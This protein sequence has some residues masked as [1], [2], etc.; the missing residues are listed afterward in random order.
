[1]AHI[2]SKDA[3]YTWWGL[4]Y[5][6][7][8]VIFSKSGQWHVQRLYFVIRICWEQT[9][10]KEVGTSWFIDP[11]HGRLFLLLNLTKR[12]FLLGKSSG[13]Y[14]ACSCRPRCVSACFPQQNNLAIQ[15]LPWATSLPGLSLCFDLILVS[16]VLADQLLHLAW[17]NLLCHFP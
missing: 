14:H 4:T 7:V 10:I 9:T 6:R 1:M 16:L 12:S 11:F 15:V 8:V 5:F 17:L 2:S 13:S 3:Y